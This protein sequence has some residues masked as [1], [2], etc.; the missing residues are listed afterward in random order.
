MLNRQAKK[1]NGWVLSMLASVL[2]MG[3]GISK[4][5]GGPY[6]ESGG[7][8]ERKSSGWGKK[9]DNNQGRRRKN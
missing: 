1:K 9:I 7:R 6:L 2:K 5:V 8:R 3:T 4:N